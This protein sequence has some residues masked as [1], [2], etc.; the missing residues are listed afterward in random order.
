MHQRILRA[1]RSSDRHPSSSVRIL[2][3][4]AAPLTPVLAEGLMDEFGDILYNVYGTTETGFGAI[5]RPGNLRAAPGTVGRPPFGTELRILDDSGREL[6]VGEAGHLFVGGP[7][8]F[9]GYSG[10]GSRETAGDLMN[11]GDL[12]HI[13]EQGR[14]FIDGREDDMIVSGGENV[15]PGEVENLLRHHDGVEDAAVI[16]V[17]DEEFGQ[18]L[19]AFVVRADRVHLSEAELKA[20]VKER[21]ARFKVPREVVFVDEVPRN[22]TGKVLKSQLPAPAR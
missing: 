8:I 4:A 5:A 20:Y 14:L 7:L 19:R 21:L 13:D 15:F 10:G 18:R 11:T 22:P 9:D 2:I 16:G 6:P 1:L 17:D 12:G 3:S